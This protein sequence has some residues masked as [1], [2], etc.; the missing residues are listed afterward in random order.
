MRIAQVLF[1]Q[2]FGTRRECDGCVLAGRVSVGGRV[3]DEPVSL[4]D[5]TPTILDMAGAPLP[6]DS[7]GR[8]LEPALLGTPLGI[9]PERV[10]AVHGVPD[11]LLTHRGTHRRRRW[12]PQR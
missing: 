8:S 1:S 12:R 4:V 5:V 3:I 6:K 9:E 10:A 7:D 2:G 11:G